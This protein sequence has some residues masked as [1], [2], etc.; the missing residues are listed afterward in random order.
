M[1]KQPGTLDAIAIQLAKVV[2]PLEDRINQ[3]EI[4]ELFAELGIRFPDSLAN[5]LQFQNAMVD[6]IARLEAIPGLI[7]TLIDQIEN[8]KYADAA[9]T[10]V[11]LTEAV[12]HLI[13]DIDVIAQAIDAAKASFPT[14]DVAEFVAN[15]S[16]NLVDYLVINYIESNTPVTAAVFEFLAVVE[17]SPQNVGSTNPVNPAYIKKALHLNELTRAFSDPMEHQRKLYK[18]GDGDF[19]GALLL[20]KLNKILL[21]AGLPVLLDTTV[22]PHKLTILFFELSAKT[23]QVPLPAVQLLL[24]YIFKL[25]GTYSLIQDQWRLDAGVAAQ[26]PL[27]AGIILEP[28][29]HVTIIPP[30]AGTIQGEVFLRWSVNPPPGHQKLILLGQ[31]GAGRLEIGG[32]RA[33]ARVDLT[34]ANGKAT[35]ELIIEGEL[36]GG[37]IVVDGGTGDGF[38]AKI[39]AGTHIK[40]DF[41]MLMGMSSTRGF[42][43]T[44]SSALE[45]RLPVHIEIGP[46]SLEGLTITLKVG[47]NK[48]TGVMELPISLGADIQAEL[49]P[50]V[51]VVQNM[52][53]TAK[54][55]FPSDNSGNLGGSAQLDF[56]FKPPNG[57]GLSIDAGG[58]KGAGFL[59][60]DFDKGEYIG[61]LEL[62]FQG[63][64]SLKAV[65]IINT[66]LPDGSNGF[67]LLIII[68]AEFN[69]IQ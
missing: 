28:D 2:K 45:I 49:G 20:E 25:A 67:A 31:E 23:D 64:F 34:F 63:M 35:S 61:A 13:M 47:Q 29:W 59:Y 53:I 14:I 56:T 48:D 50:L 40:A 6:A 8:E 22:T 66:E 17:R 11:D 58:I 15:L 12:V 3:G 19:D 52:G 5:D 4:L 27:Q 7:T 39:L 55:S 24:K 1:D 65:G 32:F 41:D 33:E 54:F 26:V 68:V 37:S 36:T 21:A 51:A 10:A 43:L 16:R 60:L 30:A 18:W 62:E 42:Y 38:L 69:P 9:G 46:I 57:V 44:G